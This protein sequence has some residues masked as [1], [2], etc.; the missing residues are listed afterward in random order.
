MASKFSYS[1][2]EAQL[3]KVLKKQQDELA[4]LSA[5]AKQTKMLQTNDIENSLS[6]LKDLGY[7]NEIDST[8]IELPIAANCSPLLVN[9]WDRILDEANKLSSDEI[10]LEDIFTR[11]EVASNSQY[12]AFLR[13]EFY[14]LNKLDKWDFAVAGIIGTIAALLD[15]F[16]VTKVNLSTGEVAPGSLKSGI[17]KLWDKVLPPDKV[18]ELENRFKVPFDISTNTSKI[19]QEVLGLNPKTHR[20]QSFGHD[21]LLGF[22]F[23]VKDLMK[24][25]LTAIDGSGR[26]II[27]NV[28]GAQ[29]TNF[30]NAVITEFGHL[31]SDVNAVSEKGMKLSIP[32]PLTPLLQM[33]QFGSINYNGKIFTVADLSKRMYRDGFNFNHF[34][35]MSIPVMTIHIIIHL[36][37]TLRNLFSEKYIKNKH[38]T[39]IMIFAANSIL[40]AENIGKLVITK[41]PFAINYVSWADTAMY[42]IK[43]MKY[44][45]IEYK[46]EQ[47]DHVQKIIDRQ[48]DETYSMVNDTWNRILNDRPFLEII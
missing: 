26:L 16:L 4:E 46:L 28:S 29:P 41:N 37:T 15:Y 22:I 6:L 19:S 24:G 7:S 2:S 8:R 45:M 5:D 35:G 30:I 39:D 10:T 12:M 38:K 44:V 34:L 32:A 11:E 33:V 17:E 31:L 27:Q 43:V 13:K 3:I 42:S 48:L 40:C 47:L 36:Y 18:I 23:G 25:E 14:E 20:F 21:P 9:S 1:P